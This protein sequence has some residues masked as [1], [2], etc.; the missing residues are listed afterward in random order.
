MRIEGSLLMVVGVFVA[1][2]LGRF[3]HL[4]LGLM[5]GALVAF[6][7]FMMLWDGIVMSRDGL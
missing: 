1:Y 5:I 3:V 6:F 2:F 4:V 7:G